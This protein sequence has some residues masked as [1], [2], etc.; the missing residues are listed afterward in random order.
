MKAMG[1][2]Y[3]ISTERICERYV[4]WF[5]FLFVQLTRIMSWEYACLDCLV[6]NDISNI[7]IH[8][9]HPA[10]LLR[11]WSTLPLNWALLLLLLLIWTIKYYN[12][13]KQSH[14]TSD[15]HSNNN[16][17]WK[18]LLKIASFNGNLYLLTRVCVCCE[19][20]TMHTKSDNNCMM[21][22]KIIVAL[23]SPINVTRQLNG[24]D[25][26]G[27]RG[28]RSSMQLGVLRCYICLQF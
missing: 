22:K 12:K 6:E 27:S 28:W 13:R 21:A 25:M 7:W 16:L 2:M 20:H 19:V 17:L 10:Y 11:I 15:T 18:R 8:N 3:V 5:F 1:T 24:I 26:S 9:A 23:I 14:C 4:C